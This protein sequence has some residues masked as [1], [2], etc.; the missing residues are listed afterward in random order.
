MTLM[1]ELDE[2]RPGADS[3]RGRRDSGS[4]PATVSVR[5][6]IK[7]CGR[8]KQLT[9][10]ALDAYY[11]SGV[12]GDHEHDALAA[13]FVRDFEV[14]ASP[15]DGAVTTHQSG[16]TMQEQFIELSG[17]WSKKADAWQV[18]LIPSERSLTSERGMGST[19][20]NLLDPRPQPGVEIGEIANVGPV[21][22]SE[23]LL[24]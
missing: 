23:K 7:R 21:Q 14:T 18:L 22:L 15:R 6:E 2:V 11:G 19:M 24:A 4:L 13:E 8:A 1:R 17:K 3:R 10:V 12:R 5:D 9:G 20:V 16:N